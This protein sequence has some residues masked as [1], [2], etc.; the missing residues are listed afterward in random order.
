MRPLIIVLMLMA[1]VTKV[2]TQACCCTGAG[3]NYSILPNLNKHIIGMRYTYRNYFSV[4]HSLN[5]DLNGTVTLQHLNALEIFGRFNLNRQFQL[6]VFVPVNF[7]SQS[8][9]DVVQK[10]AGLGDMSFLLQYSVLDPLKCNGKK[11]KHQLRFGLGTKLP[12]GEFKMDAND[13][14]STNLQLGTGSVDFL[15]NAIYTL[16]Y[17]QFGV[18]ANAGYK[19]NTGNSKGYRFGDRVQAGINAFYI[20]EVKEVQ[21]MPTVGANFEHQFSNKKNG[22]TLDFT[23]G[24]FLNASIGFDIYYRQFAFSSSV[25]PALVNRM[26]WSGENKNRFN[27]EAGVFYNFSTNK[28]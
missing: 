5:S 14:F 8:S 18:N 2:Y 21:L 4:S 15:A 1:S 17:Q 24:D 7:I 28:K 11:L 6:S 20:I 16:R 9:K 12:T 22:R 19:L 27:V 13:L 10:A 25:S 26:K 3:A 23:G